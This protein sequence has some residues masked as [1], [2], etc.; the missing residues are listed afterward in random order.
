MPNKAATSNTESF[1]SQIP[2]SKLLLAGLWLDAWLDDR[3]LAGS[4]FQKQAGEIRIWR[5]KAP[6]DT[7]LCLHLPYAGSSYIPDQAPVAKSA[8]R[9]RKLAFVLSSASPT[10]V[11]AWPSQPGCASRTLGQVFG[12]G[13]G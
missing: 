1:P 3:G 8:R 12:M 4:A 6:N 10:C 13:L 7:P 11:H 2:G 5:K 9:V